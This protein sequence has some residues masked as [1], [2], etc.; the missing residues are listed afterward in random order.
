MHFDDFL[1]SKS[2][3]NNE[4][5]H[6]IALTFRHPSMPSTDSFYVCQNIRAIS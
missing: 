5:F 2:N 1:G 4:N 6:E 3:K